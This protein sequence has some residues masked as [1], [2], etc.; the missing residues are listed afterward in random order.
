MKRLLLS[1][2]SVAALTACGGGSGGSSSTTGQ[3]SGITG[4]GYKTASQSGVI[5]QNNEFNFKDGETIT[6]F[7]GGAE[8]ASAPVQ[9]SMTLMNFFPTLPSDA[10]GL[11]QA[12]RLPEYARETL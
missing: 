7:L 10:A 8:L 2:I 12:L 5:N 1:A 11:R 3:I 6:L 4:L 9:H